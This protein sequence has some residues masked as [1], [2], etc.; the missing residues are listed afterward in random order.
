MGWI[1]QN[2]VGRG[3]MQDIEAIKLLIFNMIVNIDTCMFSSQ[4][5]EK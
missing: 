4:P 1:I 5:T 3:K 2:S